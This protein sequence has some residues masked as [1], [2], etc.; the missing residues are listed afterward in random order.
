MV[1]TV[2][3]RVSVIGIAAATLAAAA[4][5][6]AEETSS[7]TW[8][9]TVAEALLSGAAFWQLEAQRHELLFM[10][11]V[12]SA[13]GLAFEMCIPFK[14]QC[15]LCSESACLCTDDSM[16]VVQLRLCDLSP[17]LFD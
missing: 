2:A 13:R 1:F 16:F 11:Y 7:I 8:L 10:D 5:A 17:G 9:G 15:L 4:A 12:L 6:G 14:S 3:K